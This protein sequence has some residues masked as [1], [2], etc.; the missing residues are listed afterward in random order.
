MSRRPCCIDTNIL[1]NFLAGDIF[2]TLFL[3]PL[4]FHTSDIVAYE[5]SGLY[6]EKQLASFGLEILALNDIETQEILSLQE[7][8][9]ELSLEDISVL[10]LSQKH[11]TMILSNDGPLRKL[12][13]ASRIEYHGTLWLL[14]EMIQKEI[15]QPREAA[16]ALRS[17][18]K[19][20]R[21]L[22]R[23]ECETL[24]KKWESGE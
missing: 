19:N 1:F 7:D 24:I 8:H 18:L 22:P 20:K 15:L 16:S 5:I 11:H 6:S 17:M 10:F 4:D 23:P 13:D 2:D 12:A 21:W 3:L 9:I 14:E